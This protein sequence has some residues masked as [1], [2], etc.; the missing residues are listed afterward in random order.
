M[1]TANINHSNM[2]IKLIYLFDFCTR[3][4]IRKKITR[5]CESNSFQIWI[6]YFE[7]LMGWQI[8]YFKSRALFPVYL[9]DGMLFNIFLFRICE[10]HS[11]EMWNNP[12]CSRHTNFERVSHSWLHRLSLK[13]T[14]E[15][16][17]K[18]LP[19]YF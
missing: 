7:K 9:L 10:K 12:E 11:N 1:A 18:I 2:K 15:Y 17:N 14:K 19:M 3:I 16:N 6:Y 8:F 5:V 4:H 13:Y